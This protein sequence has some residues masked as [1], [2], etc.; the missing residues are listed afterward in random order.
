M[1]E[2]PSTLYSTPVPGST[3][4]SASEADRVTVTGLLCQ[5]VSASSFTLGAVLS[6]RIVRTGVVVE[7]PTWSGT[8]ARSW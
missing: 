2:P 4:D 3:L 8:I 5:F 7:F 1:N 6:T